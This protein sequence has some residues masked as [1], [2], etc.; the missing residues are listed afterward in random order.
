MEAAVVDHQVAVVV[1][2]QEEVA[3]LT[4][5]NSVDRSRQ[6]DLVHVGNKTPSHRRD[7]SETV[8]PTTRAARP[9][10]NSRSHFA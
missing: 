5:T 7:V 1:T 3:I 6:L 2:D 10:L 9:T 4:M 8:F